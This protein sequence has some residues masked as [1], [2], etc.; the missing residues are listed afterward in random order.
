MASGENLGGKFTIDISDLRKSLTQAN[1]LIKESESKFKASAAGMDDWKTSTEGLTAKLD[2][3]NEIEE[4]QAEKVDAT[5]RAYDDLIANGM[6][7]ASNQ[8]VQMRTDINNYTAA[9]ETTRR[10]IDDTE[11][12]L[13]QLSDSET[14][15][16]NNADTA[17]D[18]VKSAGDAAK[19]AGDGFTV[20]KGL[21]VEFIS[22]GLEKLA[23]ACKN[24]VSKLLELPAATQEIT[25]SFGKL[26]TSFT[27]N[28]FS[29]EQMQTAYTDFYGVLGDNDKTTEALGNLAQLATSQQDLTDWTT[30]ATGVYATFGDGLPIESLTEAANE[31]A[32]VG[33]VTG[34]LADALNWVGISEDDFNERLAACNSEQERA[35]LITD[36]L[37]GQ[38][39]EAA[40]TYRELNGDVIA[41]NESQAEYNQTQAELGDT[42]RPITTEIQDGVND[43]TA[44]FTDMINDVDF[45]QVKESISGAFDWF[46]NTAMPKIKDGATWAMDNLPTI[47]TLVAGGLAAV[48]AQNVAVA[49][50]TLAAKAAEEGLTVSQYLLNAA[51]NANPIGLIILAITALVAAFVYL[52]NNCEEFRNFFI[53]M[54]ETIKPVVETAWNFIKAVFAQAW[55]QIKIVWDAVQP[56]FSAIW[57]AIKTIFSVVSETLGEYF[58]LA[59]EAI[60]AVW[61]IVGGYFQVVWETIK[62]IF[63]VVKDV[64]SGDF[65]SAWEKIK[66]IVSLW[67]E[68]FREVWAK[69]KAIFSV[70]GDWFKQK[71]S[72]AWEKIK[73][74]FSTVGEFFGG[75]WDTIK[76]KFTNIGQKVGEAIGGAFKTAI[77]FVLSTAENVLNAPI[78]AI[79]NLLDLINDVPGI[80]IGT[81]PTFSLPRLARGGIINGATPLI[82]GEAG[83]EAI[84]PLENN[85]GWL[86]EVAAM[87]A[88]EMKTA[89]GG[90]INREVII[91]QTNNYT[92]AHSR[93]ELFKTKQETEAAVKLALLG[94]N[95]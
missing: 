12:A 32:K 33:T 15:A 62:T 8:A 2:S 95:K 66:G 51:M 41:A 74:V 90:T 13:E 20:G 77:N 28:G 31:T 76:E 45:E 79:N 88:E 50:S 49:A 42:L 7:P 91:N 68:Y 46:I 67:A 30:I 61:D 65:S 11:S 44:A 92:A 81:L 86:R 85:L 29:V 14:E 19:E 17:G 27:T 39:S 78:N 54:W 63:S 56:Y 58:A 73:G 1:K 71:F 40:A 60:K 34:A 69:I 3:L 5:T 53:G 37:N 83:R 24:A 55:E 94:V 80:N 10:Q 72:T 59:W 21:I 82:A 48:A 35:Q 36:T 43:V 87:L 64:L 18:K 25:E 57:E 84:I 22:G 6:N 16:G 89:N 23:G 75:I 52:W 47:L 93:Y 38:Y 70:V 4:L 26:E 9:L